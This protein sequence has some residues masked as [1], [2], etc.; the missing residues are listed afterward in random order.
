MW[1]LGTL[2]RPEEREQSSL[3]KSPHTLVRPS[4]LHIPRLAALP[5]LVT[6][7]WTLSSDFS[8]EVFLC[9]LMLSIPFTS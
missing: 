5:L 6:G 1:A 7:P 4:G 8:A 2:R 9:E 3:N